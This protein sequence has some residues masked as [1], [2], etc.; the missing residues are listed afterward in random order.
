MDK[1]TL[2]LIIGIITAMISLVAAVGV[3]LVNA[4]DGPA[5]GPG[6]C[7]AGGDY[8]IR[9]QVTVWFEPIGR[10]LIMFVMSGAIR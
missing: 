4:K 3:L 7:V 5:H 8:V 1:E 2:T 10:G 9:D 6:G